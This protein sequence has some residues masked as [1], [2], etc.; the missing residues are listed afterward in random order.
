M[1]RI[2]DYDGIRIRIVPSIKD[3][4]ASHK[5][6]NIGNNAP[7]GYVPFCRPAQRQPIP[8]GQNIDTDSIFAV[9]FDEADVIMKTACYGGTPDEL[10]TYFRKN[11]TVP[12]TGPKSF[13]IRRIKDALP[14]WFRLFEL[15]NNPY[16]KAC[17]A[18]D[19]KPSDISQLIKL[20]KD[21]QFHEHQVAQDTTGSLA[22]C[23]VCG[24]SL[25]WYCPDSPTHLCDYRQEDESYDEDCCRYCGQPEERK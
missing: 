15:D 13:I 12:V 17:R 6:W 22:V 16:E 20:D 8:G 1:E 10:L 23:S 21:G 4:P 19:L 9:P 11:G 5:V 3:V 25:G 7:K 2:I 18:Y 24:N 14:A